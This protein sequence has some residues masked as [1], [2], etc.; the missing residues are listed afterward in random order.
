ME[1][2]LMFSQVSTT[3]LAG[4]YVAVFHQQLFPVELLMCIFSLYSDSDFQELPELQTSPN[5]IYLRS[6]LRKFGWNKLR[7]LIQVLGKSGIKKRE[8]KWKEW[9]DRQNA[10]NYLCFPVGEITDRENWMM[11]VIHR[12]GFNILWKKTLWHVLFLTQ[13]MLW[14]WAIFLSMFY[15]ILLF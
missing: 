15:N 14:V 11:M 5:L 1:F 8:R 3:W 4:I 2:M 9:S 13:S 12:G 6:C 7:G 10:W